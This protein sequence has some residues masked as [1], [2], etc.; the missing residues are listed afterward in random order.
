M[1][2]KSLCKTNKSGVAGVG[3]HKR[4]K[5]WQASIAYDK[6]RLFLGSFKHLEDAIKARKA[7]EMKYFGEFA[8]R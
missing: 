6:T 2:N 7:A 4:D 8:P 3:F 5:T 1:K